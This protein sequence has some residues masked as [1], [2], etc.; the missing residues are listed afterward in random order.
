MKIRQAKKD[1]FDQILD[2]T[3][4]SYGFDVEQ[5]SERYKKKYEDI[6]DEE[7]VIDV[8]G[9]ITTKARN[10]PF[11]QN[12]RGKLIPM[13]GISMVASDP[14]NRRQGHV[15][16]LMEYLIQMMYEEN[17][18]VSALYPFKDTFYAKFG[19]VN[20]NPYK[21]LIISPEQLRRWKTLPEG[22]TV[23]RMN[24]EESFD[25][26]K[27]LHE[28]F[29]GKIHGGVIRSEKR[30]K[31]YAENPKVKVAVAY[32]SKGK[33]E[34]IMRYSIKG[35]S[36]GFDWAP[37]GEIN[38]EEFFTTSPNGKIALLNFLFLFTDQI[39]KVLLPIYSENSEIYTWLNGFYK[40][41]I[42]SNNIWMARVV[43]VKK[44]LQGMPTCG[45]DKIAFKVVD[46][47]IKANNTTFQISAK[48]KK[49]VVEETKDKT[50]VLE[51]TIEGLTALV[52][53]AL[54]AE[55]LDSF[56]WLKDASTADKEILDN[57]FPRK[58]AFL[59]EGF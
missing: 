20:I 48:D 45:E 41:D 5:A 38:A 39:R 35:F 53:G 46:P 18:N 43:D 50:G 47:I 12:V 59:S 34:G 27:K 33:P 40:V 42:K 1:D 9:K 4:I 10:I 15:R 49:I 30:W 11:T 22:Y 37:D 32:N 58:V 56:G 29:V 23:K 57:F 52:F 13:A 16:K 28:E 3:A 6:M 55:E 19:Y 24:N 14:T 25:I 54:S 17:L 36:S 51:L 26:Y 31:E 7:F 44:T 21:Q 8:E 2:I